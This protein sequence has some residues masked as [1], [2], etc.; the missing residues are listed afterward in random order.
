[1][2]ILEIDPV[3]I[4]TLVACATPRT[5]IVPRVWHSVKSTTWTHHECEPGTVPSQQSQLCI[6]L[7][8]GSVALTCPE[9]VCVLVGALTLFVVVLKYP[10]SCQSGPDKGR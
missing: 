3:Y 1:M 10:Q 6:E 2:V 8:L 7:S 4:V 9:L 5:P